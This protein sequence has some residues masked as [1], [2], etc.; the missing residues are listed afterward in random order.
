MPKLNRRANK[1]HRR[2]QEEIQARQHVDAAQ[3]LAKQ[4]GDQDATG[5]DEA[6][7]PD[8][9]GS[10]RGVRGA[11]LT[12][13]RYLRSDARLAAKLMSAGVVD[14]EIAAGLM[15]QSYFLANEAFNQRRTRAFCS[16]MRLI[17]EWPRLEIAH[18]KASGGFVPP[19]VLY[20][21]ASNAAA[22]P[23]P[24]ARD[25]QPAAE[26]PVAFLEAASSDQLMQTAR[27]LQE[28][29]IFESLDRETLDA[30]PATGP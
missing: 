12:S 25:D 18:R 3:V 17:S 26:Q 9:D 28:L 4:Q 10:G 27:I 22:Q 23:H 19:S 24:P 2:K 29:G 5:P 6:G 30:G 20:A 15:R 21:P 1:A 7:D 16:L 11:L 8:D 14:E 13:S